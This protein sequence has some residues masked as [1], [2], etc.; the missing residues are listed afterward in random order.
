MSKQTHMI[1]GSLLALLLVLPCCRA[2]RMVQPMPAPRAIA[3]KNNPT[4]VLSHRS[5]TYGFFLQAFREEKAAPIVFNRLREV[6]PDAPIYIMGDQGGIDFARLCYGEDA[7]LCH[8]TFARVK[9]GHEFQKLGTGAVRDDTI[10]KVNEFFYQQA[11]AANWTGCTYLVHVEN[12]VWMQQP[13]AQ[14]HQ[15][16]SW[17][18][19]GGIY[20][21]WY[22][23]F[24]RSVASY[25]ENQT[26]AVPMDVTRVIFTASYW[27]SEAL[28]DAVR[29][30]LP[31]IDW[32]AINR[33]DGR[34]PLACDTVVPVL[35]SLAGYRTAYWNG[36][37]ERD[38]VYAQ[39]TSEQCS[40]APLRHKGNTPATGFHT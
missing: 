22:R 37:C 36:A 33:L 39:F 24:S 28:V 26:G 18:A 16:P 11:A 15:P 3:P 29:R 1:Q 5:C 30:V 13:F 2:L 21:P 19:A 14:K 40:E 27:K 25:V 8:F 34:I 10:L 4:E 35:A 23:E 12:D 31:R 7:S 38:H 20:N 6:Y 9:L 32:K 17:S